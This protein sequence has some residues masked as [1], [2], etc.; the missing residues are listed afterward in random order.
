MGRFALMIL[1]VILASP[2]VS[3]KCLMSYCKDQGTTSTL[4]RSY[5]TNTSRQIIGDLYDPGHGRRLQIRDRDR[6]ILG[7]I[8]KDGTI[9]N[10]RRQRV[11]TIEALR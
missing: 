5:I 9:T 6:R 8:E 1:A 7:F 4:S 11:G 10:T 3:A 2:P